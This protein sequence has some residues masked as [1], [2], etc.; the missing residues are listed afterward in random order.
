MSDV[1]ITIS[2]HGP[3]IVNGEI[4]LLDGEGKKIDT[5]QATYLCRCGLSTNKP[6]CTGAHKDKFE[7]AV[8][9]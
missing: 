1:K 4:E 9:A 7:S 5:K 2:D 8:R 6:F 3:L